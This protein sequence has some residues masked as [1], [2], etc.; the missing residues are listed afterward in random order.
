MSRIIAAVDDS[1]AAARVLAAAQALSGPFGA[2]VEALTV[3]R[4]AG[5]TAA[6]TAAR[7]RVPFRAVPG[8]PLERLVE[9]AAD[10]DVVAFAIG[11]RSHA[12]TGVT[13]HLCL[14]LA[15]QVVQPVLA[16]PP[17]VPVPARFR[18][19]L[20]AMEGRPGRVRHLRRALAPVAIGDLELIIVH[21]DD[22]ESLPM[23]SD[24]GAYDTE[25]YAAEFLARYVPGVPV[26]RL[27][28]RVG[29]PVEEI[30][31]SCEEVRPDLLALGWPHDTRDGVGEVAHAV[32][33]RAPRPV[34]L[35][36]TV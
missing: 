8:D 14:G 27:H 20:M 6:A 32:L 4:S 11:Q 29:S 26:A 24:H 35:V 1:S 13:G 25:A 9:L 5:G 18:R 7:A 28:L 33:E 21:V 17:R 19:V 2:E 12:G 34:L 10:D 22:E 31:R 23:F 36:A 30:L 15:G 3:A 16:V